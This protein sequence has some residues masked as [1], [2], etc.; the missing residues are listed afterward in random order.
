MRA[1][2]VVLVLADEEDLFGVFL[3]FAK[4]R[5]SESEREEVE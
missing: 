5:K 2:G 3:W 4:E 1:E